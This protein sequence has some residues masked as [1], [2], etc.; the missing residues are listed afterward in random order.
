MFSNGLHCANSLLLDA[1]ADATTQSNAG[2]I[3]PAIR[4]ACVTLQ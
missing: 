3:N 2:H 4:E 1:L